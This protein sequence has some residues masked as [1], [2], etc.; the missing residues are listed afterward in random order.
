MKYASSVHAAI[1]STGTALCC[2]YEVTEF[3]VK[4]PDFIDVALT[5][6]GSVIPRWR[7][8]PLAADVCEVEV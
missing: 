6:T 1:R 3:L 2:M 8:S 7:C 5:T 4:V